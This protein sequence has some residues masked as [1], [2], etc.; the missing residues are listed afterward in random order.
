VKTPVLICL[1]LGLALRLIPVP[2][3]PSSGSLLRL[4]DGAAGFL[5][6]LASA[7]HLVAS[8]T[9]PVVLVAIGIRMRPSALKANIVGVCI[10]GVGRLVLAPII[11]FLV[12]RYVLQIHDPALL[13]ICVAISG[14]PPSASATVMAGQYDMDGAL[15][16]AAFVAL[17]ILYAV[18]MPLMLTFL[19]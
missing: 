13:M 3:A 8:A 9:I 15:G 12:A 18:S 7:V 4:Y 19:H 5:G 6:A 11:G 1:A 2:H 17:T 14:T 10:I 16:V